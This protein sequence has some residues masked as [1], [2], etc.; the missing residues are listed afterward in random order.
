VQWYSSF[1]RRFVASVIDI[2]VILLF[3][4]LIQFILGVMGGTF[5]NI[6][7]F[8]MGWNYFALQE[9]STRKGTVGKQ[10]MNLIVTDLD[11]NKISFKQATK[12]FLGKFLAA[13]PFFAGFLLIFF[14]EKRQA[15][16]DIIAKTVV[17]IQED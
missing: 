14:T 17:F 12:R 13:I 3:I 8:L 1:F 4:A 16:H 11:G 7:I 15:L 5:F 10:A 6:I 2:F 9:S